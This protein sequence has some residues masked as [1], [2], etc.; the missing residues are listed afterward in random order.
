MHTHN[1][2]YTCCNQ[3]LLDISQNMT[4]A[5]TALVKILSLPGLYRP[6]HPT[7]GALEAGIEV[8]DTL[9]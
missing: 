1:V 8:M 9:Q 3:Y 6:I 2:C 5:K 7:Y 4:E